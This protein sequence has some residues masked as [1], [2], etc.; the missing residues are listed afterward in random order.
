MVD[1]RF[2]VQHHR[3]SVA[4]KGK[5]GL[6]VVGLFDYLCPG[7]GHDFHNNN[8]SYS[9]SQLPLKFFFLLYILTFAELNYL[10]FDMASIK[11]THIPGSLA[12]KATSRASSSALFVCLH[13]NGS[14][15]RRTLEDSWKLR[16]A[17]R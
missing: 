17:A 15:L 3:Q 6:F 8:K 4:M 2:G 12:V 9:L 16:F 1:G 13:S 10:S 5:V 14:A 7:I 11:T